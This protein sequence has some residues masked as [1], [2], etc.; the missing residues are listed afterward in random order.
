MNIGCHVSM[1]KGLTHAA[2]DVFDIG[3]N[4]F[5]FFSRNPRGGSPPKFGIDDIENFNK[6]VNNNNFGFMVAHAPYVLNLCSAKEEVR[7]FS[8]KMLEEDLVFF[9]EIPRILYNFHPGTHGGQGVRNGV[10][11]ISDALNCVLN[12]NIKIT[13][14]L[15]T[16]AG[17]GNEIGANFMEIKQI[18][19]N[20]DNN[21][22]LGVC[23]DT[24]H[25]Y[26]A[27]YDIVNNLNGV[28]EDFDKN[29]G[30]NRL[31][32]LHLNDSKNKLMSK[33]DRHEKLG[34]GTLGIEPFRKIINHPVLENLIFIL[35][36]PND[37]LGYK[38]EI[39]FLQGLLCD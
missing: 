16:M 22:K 34:Q 23:L 38:N 9:N 10:K 1:S 24:C 12:K 30:L 13:V 7:K 36:T 8:L 20:V 14:L 26:D 25:I 2:K 17:K 18:I 4:T 3:G 15:E 21:E 11:F 39:L 31:K 32:V 29:I 5:Q 6:F 27:G 28:L 37:L 19:Q 33:K 35:E